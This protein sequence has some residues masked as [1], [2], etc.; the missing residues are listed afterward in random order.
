MYPGA[1]VLLEISLWWD[2]EALLG[3]EGWCALELA[4]TS[5]EWAWCVL[6]RVTAAGVLLQAEEEEL[7]LTS[8][9]ASGRETEQSFP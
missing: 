4:Q 2:G 7:L 3:L 6:G 8:S 9:G 1:V 5:T